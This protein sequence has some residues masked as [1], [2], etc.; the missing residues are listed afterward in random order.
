MPPLRI[1]H[2]MTSVNLGG[3]ASFVLNLIHESKKYNIEVHIILTLTSGDVYELFSKEGVTFHKVYERYNFKPFLSYTLCKLLR[4]SAKFTY[5]LRLFF[6]LRTISPDLVHSHQFASHWLS[7]ILI[8]RILKIPWLLHLHSSANYQ[9][10]KIF[11]KWV[12]PRL[13]NQH[14]AVNLP[15]SGIHKSY[16]SFTSKISK[17]LLHLPYGIPF[18]PINFEKIK[19][20]KKR[21][22]L[23]DQLIIGYVGRL[24]D[25]KRIQDIINATHTLN[26]ENLNIHTIIVGDGRQRKK[27]EN[28]VHSLHL[29]NHITFTG[30]QPNPH[31]WMSLI[32]IFILPS[33]YEGFPISIIEAK[34][35]G[36]T[37]IGSDVS[38]TQDAIQHNKNGLLFPVK[39]VD[40]LTD[41]L[42]D[43]IQYPE[44][45]DE[46][47]RVALQDFKNN[48]E[49]S[50]CTK[51]Y[52]HAYRKL[53]TG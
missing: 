45:R 51:K 12:I 13:F 8:S 23:N 26:S 14:I 32:D 25:Q 22:K 10:K 50:H 31:H 33:L 36:A 11:S 1:V 49:L 42:R 7:Q 16:I 9:G 46:L 4:H 15:S 21:L 3:I 38:G 28:L 52:I 30:Y 53:I 48:Y 18:H 37:I 47:N 6:K 24:I 44:K 29:E 20:T 5:G 43:L 40:K 35:Y 2:L 27:F 41:H 19:E 34:A 17:R 39:D